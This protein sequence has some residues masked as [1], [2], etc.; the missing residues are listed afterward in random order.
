MTEEE[1][2]A[3]FKQMDVELEIKR[4]R[5]GEII[6]QVKSWPQ[7]GRGSYAQKREQDQQGEE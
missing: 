5:A 6:R 3:F 7:R 2:K 1:V 4:K